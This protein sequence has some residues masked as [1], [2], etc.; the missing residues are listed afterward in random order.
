MKELKGH[1]YHSGPESGQRSVRISMACLT[2]P[3][4]FSFFVFGID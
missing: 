4:D 1:L 2:V 3:H